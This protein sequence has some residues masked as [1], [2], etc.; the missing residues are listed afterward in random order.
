MTEPDRFRQ[1]CAALELD[2]KA[3]ERIESWAADCYLPPTA[4]CRVI[5]MAGIDF[6]ATELEDA[7]QNAKD[8]A[9]RIDLGARPQC[10]NCGG[11][12][13]PAFACPRCQRFRA[14]PRPGDPG[15]EPKEEP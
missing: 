9:D 15:Y 3:A 6:G 1:L 10:Y 4:L 2:D 5:L 7:I 13:N 12:T 11:R 8:V 14:I